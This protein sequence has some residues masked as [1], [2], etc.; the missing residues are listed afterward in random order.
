M[1]DLATLIAVKLQFEPRM[2][3]CCSAQGRLLLASTYGVII[4]INNE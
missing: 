4:G 2:K 3:K 1:A